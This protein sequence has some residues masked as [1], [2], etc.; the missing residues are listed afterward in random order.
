MKIVTS[1]EES[2]LLIKGVGEK[3]KQQNKK[4]QKNNL[5]TSWCFVKYIVLIRADEDTIRVG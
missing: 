3:N 1:L 2:G 5:R 4:K